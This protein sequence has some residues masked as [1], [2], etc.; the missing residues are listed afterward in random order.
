M[1]RILAD[2]DGKS[3]PGKDDDGRAR[4]QELTRCAQKLAEDSEAGG[5]AVALSSKVSS[6]RFS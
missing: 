4:W 2:R 5:L 1:Y 3:I 6:W